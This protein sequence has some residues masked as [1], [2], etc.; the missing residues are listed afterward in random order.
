MSQSFTEYTRQGYFGR[1]GGAIAGAVAGVVF[2][3]IAVVILFWNEGRAVRTA[4]MLKEAA[5]VVV[6]ID[7]SRVD[8]AGDGRLVHFTTDA[9][10]DTLED[11]LFHASRTAVRLKRMAEMFQWRQAEESH[12]HTDAVG[13]GSTT[14]KTYTYSQVW[15]DK[16][17]DSSQFHIRTGHENPS[18]KRVESETWS[19]PRVQAGAFVLPAELVNRIDNF[20]PVPLTD[21]ERSRL[22]EAMQAD[23]VIA[24]GKCYVAGRAGRG[25]DPDHPQTGDVRVTLAAAPPGPVSVIDRQAA[26]TIAAYSTPSGGSVELLYV[27]AHPAKEMITSEEHRNATLTWVLRLVGFVMMWIAIGAML[28]PLRVLA[29]VIGILGDLVGAG[30]GIVAFLVALAVSAA[31]IAIAWVVYRPLLG[32][33]LLA[34]AAAAT[35]GLFVLWQR[36]AARRRIAPAAPV[37]PGGAVPNH[38]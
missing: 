1:I 35:T 19:A 5:A 17:I 24:D 25:V 30:V 6:T 13:G 8:P 36:R 29:G 7:P 32:C 22:P 15:S 34:L 33:A 14:E 28:Q 23:A 10:G 9:Q 31:T 12:S 11:P 18:S 21:A 27:G 2:L 37:I 4:K 38:R 20:A 3:L 16:P 26:A